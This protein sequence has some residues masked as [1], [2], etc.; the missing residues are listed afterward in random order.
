MTE[1]P[2]TKPKQRE[3]LARLVKLA[4]NLMISAGKEPSVELRLLKQ[5]LHDL[6]EQMFNRKGPRGR[7]VSEPVTA[8]KIKEVF[9]LRDEHP[10]W[11]QQEI[12]YQ[13]NINIGRVSEI[14]HGKRE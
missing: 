4:D 13:A 8:A 14:L 9:R 2:S 7:P 1:L 6:Y 5:G 11:S 12:A 10:S 3:H